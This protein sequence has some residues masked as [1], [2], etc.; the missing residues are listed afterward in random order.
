MKQFVLLIFL[1]LNIQISSAQKDENKKLINSKNFIVLGDFGRFGEYNQ[2]EVA[3]QMAKTAVEIDVDFVVSVGDNFYPNGVQSIQDPHF[4]KSFENIY[5]HFDL[6]C[7]WYLGLGNH[8]Y[9]GNIQAQ[10]DYSNVSRRWH[11]PEQYFE[12]IIELKGGKKLQLIFIDTNPFIKSYYKNDDEKARNVKKQDTIAQKRWLIETLNKKDTSILWKIVVG[13]HPM[14][15]GGKR[16]KS[17]D[18]KDIET[19]LSGLFND[20][21]V[22]AYLCGHEHDL[23][24]IKSKNCYTTQFLSGAGSEVRPTGNR[25]GTI[26]ALSVP[27]FMAFSVN[28]DKILVRLINAFGTDLFTYQVNKVNE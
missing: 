13:H 8:D 14:Y 7:D 16:V 23:Q 19:L 3:N 10:I 22:D 28:E 6:Q 21:K 2:K 27:G 1:V 12:K 5:P 17:P 26:F 9:S 18:T 4:E 11:M 15:T 24:I 20:Y 25:E